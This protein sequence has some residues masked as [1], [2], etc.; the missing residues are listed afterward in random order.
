MSV[1]GR[2]QRGEGGGGIGRRDKGSA[3]LGGGGQARM[4]GGVAGKVVDR[5]SESGEDGEHSRACG[6][7]W[8]GAGRDFSALDALSH[9]ILETHLF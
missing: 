6:G 3:G 9:T 4:G 7:V 8:A 5:R 2:A 1:V